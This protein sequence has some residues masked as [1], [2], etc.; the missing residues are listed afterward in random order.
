LISIETYY[1][2]K[3]ISV[4]KNHMHHNNSKNNNNNN[5]NSDSDNNSSNNN[6][7]TTNQQLV[8]NAMTMQKALETA[9]NDW[10]KEKLIN[11]NQ[12]DQESLNTV[13]S[14]ADLDSEVTSKLED[15]NLE[16]ERKV[17]DPI[18]IKKKK[19][20]LD[21]SLEPSSSLS[22]SLPSDNVVTSK[23]KSKT[24]KTKQQKSL[25]KL[26]DKSEQSELKAN[27]TARSSSSLTNSVVPYTTEIAY[28]YGNPTVDLVKGFIHIYKDW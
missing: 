5:N 2:D 20:H 23:L 27:E 8:T 26:I 11:T 7:N 21:E 25:D 18:Q 14:A 24:D 16:K 13:P 10:N 3:K 22:S 4:N 12:I 28:Y 1:F 15:L 6:T 19:H 17:S 9:Y